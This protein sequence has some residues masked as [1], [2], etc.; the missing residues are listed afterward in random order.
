MNIVTPRCIFCGSRNVIKWCGRYNKLGRKQR[1]Q[2]KECSTKKGRTVTFTPDDGFRWRHHSPDVI[3]ETLSLHTRGMSES[4]A[5]DHM[6]QHHGVVVGTG[7]IKRWI[8]EY[9]RRVGEYTN[10]LE[11]TIKGKMRS[12]SR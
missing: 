8:E 5:S 6:W 4:E 11:P 1:Y 9:S 12:W 2:C 7:T 10:S 3:V